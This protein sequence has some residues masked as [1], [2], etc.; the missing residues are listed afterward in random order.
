M[1]YIFIYIEWI[2]S[3]LINIKKS[4]LKKLVIENLGEKDMFM[5]TF[6]NTIALHRSK[7]AYFFFASKWHKDATYTTVYF[8]K[9]KKTIYYYKILYKWCVHVGVICNLKR[10]FHQLIFA[11][12]PTNNFFINC[13]RDCGIKWFT[14]KSYT[15]T[16]KEAHKS[17]LL[18]KNDDD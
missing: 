11:I 2:R 10:V 15:D 16:I 8:V 1:N 14:N 7:V 6:C 5:P 17:L 13:P 4:G 9:K 3:I 18:K 12:I